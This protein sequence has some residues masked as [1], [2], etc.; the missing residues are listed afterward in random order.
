MTRSSSSPDHPVT[1]KRT[2]ADQALLKAVMQQLADE[3][4]LTFSDLCKQ[5]LQRWLV[6][7]ETS[8]AVLVLMELQQ[9]VAD[10]QHQVTTLEQQVLHHDT[11]AI[12]RLDARLDDLTDRLAHLSPGVTAEAQDPLPEE[13]IAV[14]PTPPEPDLDPLLSRLGGLLEEF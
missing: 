6:A 1:F 3:P 9:Q 10:L 12:A 13:A 14:E 5:A 8:A 11:G 4:G 7:T 2:K